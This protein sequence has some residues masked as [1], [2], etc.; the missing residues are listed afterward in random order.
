ML[1]GGPSDLAL[2]TSHCSV[3][4]SRK[5]LAYNGFCDYTNPLIGTLDRRSQRRMCMDPISIIVAALVTGAAAAL[6][7]T[8]E[9]V[10]KDAYAGMKGLVQ[11]KY[12]RVEGSQ[13]FSLPKSPLR[14]ASSEMQELPERKKRLLPWGSWAMEPA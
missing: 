13:H 10:I 8:T 14:N 5:D 6:K 2:G 4:Y 1:V 7:P 9:Q 11:R 12:T 3:L